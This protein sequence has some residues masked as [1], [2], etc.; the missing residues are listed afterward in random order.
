VAALR[1]LV[2]EVHAHQSRPR[3]RQDDQPPHAR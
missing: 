3:E 1:E 2:T